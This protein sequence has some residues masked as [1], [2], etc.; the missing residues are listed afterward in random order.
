[1][2]GQHNIKKIFLY[3]CVYNVLCIYADMCIFVHKLICNDE[4][5][6]LFIY[7]FIFVHIYVILYELCCLF[8]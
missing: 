7:L 2:H 6:Y 5:Y 8:R 1:M 3:I 4:M